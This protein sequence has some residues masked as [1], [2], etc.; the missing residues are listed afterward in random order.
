[1]RLEFL[2]LLR[3]PM[4]VPFYPVVF[5]I[6]MIITFA[7]HIIFV[8]LIIG[9]TGLSIWFSI[10]KNQFTENIVETFART[11]TIGISLAIVLGVAP[12]LFVQVIYD[13]LWYSANNISA[14]MVL[15]FLLLIALSFTISYIFYFSSKKGGHILWPVISFILLIL[16]AFIIHALSVQMIN[17]EKWTS[18]IYNGVEINLYGN[19]L[20]A[21]NI[22]RLLHFIIPS[23]AIT[24]VYMM[25]YSWYYKD[26]E[27]ISK[28]YIEWVAETGRKLALTFSIIQ[29][30]VGAIWYV[31]D[32]DVVKFPTHPI[33]LIGITV[34]LAYIGYL[35]KLKDPIDKAIPTAIFTLIT[36]LFMST[37]RETLR[38]V[39]LSNLGY[40]IYTYKVSIDWGSTILFLLTFL[41]GIVVVWYIAT[42]V[43]KMGKS[44]EK[45]VDLS[46]LHKFG[47]IAASLPVIW[48]IVVAGFGIVLAI[49]NKALP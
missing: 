31:S 15:G 16:S 39:K 2:N 29:G 21:V 40:S 7:L 6:L 25:L 33:T 47:K 37:V 17:P 35:M 27:D 5:E 26:R 19:R 24:G 9:G 34:A 22:A 28:A 23:F 36:V 49:K 8:N 42:V 20:H 11:T 48:F 41:M 18:W 4:G 3:D 1:M 45:P 30:I 13:P 44:K 43:Y 14:W 12:L 32:F 38:N 46:S 10:N